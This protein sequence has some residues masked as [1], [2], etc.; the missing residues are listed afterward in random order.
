M[1]QRLLRENVIRNLNLRSSTT[2]YLYE[3]GKVT[4]H[5]CMILDGRVEVEFGKDKVTFEGGPFVYFGVQALIG[6]GFVI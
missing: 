4:D 1:L 3:V 5:F 6:K 2:P